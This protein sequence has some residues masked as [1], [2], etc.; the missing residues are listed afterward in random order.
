M[1]LAPILGVFGCVLDV[2]LMS[3]LRGFGTESMFYMFWWRVRARDLSQKGVFWVTVQ[4]GGQSG[5]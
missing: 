4:V 1:F 2:F 5:S 3:S